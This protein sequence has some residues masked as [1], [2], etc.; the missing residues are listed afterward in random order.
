M[1]GAQDECAAQT[2]ML[3]LQWCLQL[4]CEAQPPNS[5]L[6]YGKGQILVFSDTQ[7]TIA[8]VG[9]ASEMWWHQR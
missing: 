4:E 5:L 9:V 6:I 3:L 1:E 2:C 7:M 8:V